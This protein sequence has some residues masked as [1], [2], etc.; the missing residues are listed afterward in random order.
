MTLKL[1]HNSIFYVL[2]LT[3]TKGTRLSKITQNDK[4]H[5]L[6]LLNDISHIHIHVYIAIRIQN[7]LVKNNNNNRHAT[8]LTQYW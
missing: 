3:V 8:I 2:V 1:S 7:S 4:Y 6:I 5:L